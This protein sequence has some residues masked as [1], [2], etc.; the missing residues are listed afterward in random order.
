MVPARS[1]KVIPR[2]TTRPSIWWNTG[3]WRAAPAMGLHQPPGD[4]ETEARPARAP[5]FRSPEELVEQPGQLGRRDPLADVVNGHRQQPAVGVIP[6]LHPHVGAV[7]VLG[8]LL[9]QA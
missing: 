5:A 7:G 9:Q 4:V 3:E 6:T 2:S 1:P 8:R